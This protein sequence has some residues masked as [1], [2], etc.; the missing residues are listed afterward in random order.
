[1]GGLVLGVEE[2]TKLSGIR[3]TATE[4]IGLRSL[5][6]RRKIQDLE[7]ALL[8]QVADEIVLMHPLHDHDDTRGRLVVAARKQGGPVPFDDSRPHGLRHGVAKLERIVDDDQVSS[9]PGRKLREQPLDNGD[10]LTL[11]FHASAVAD[12]I[13]G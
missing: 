7:T 12:A 13:S 2:L 9:E 3:A 1:M 6:D 11:A 10:S 8:L 5:R 4:V